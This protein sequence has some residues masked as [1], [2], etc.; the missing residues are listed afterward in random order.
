MA[1]VQGFTVLFAP[2]SL[3]GI[4]FGVWVL[5]MILVPVVRWVAGEGAERVGIA[6]GVIAQVGLVVSV[7]ISEFRFWALPVVIGVPLLGWLSEV[8]GS[9]TGI[10]FGR[11]S[12]TDVL[13]PQIAHV[14]L[15][16]PL[17]W[18]MMIPPS[19]AI[20]AV[21]AP[22]S[23]VL[24][25]LVAAAAFTAWDLY[26]DPQMVSWEFWKWERNGAYLGIPVSNYAGWFGVAF[27]I[28][29][30]F[31]MISRAAPLHLVVQVPQSPLVAVFV[32]TWILQF[33]G[34]MVFWKLRVSAVVGFL[35][36]GAFVA[37]AALR[38]AGVL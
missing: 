4:L 35:V 17:A 6:A 1:L 16:I 14:P 22:H 30:I 7:L 36:M 11:Y 37:L 31:S 8:I 27:L 13:K 34:Q 5:V 3:Q 20:G 26:L 9:R 19:W 28:A 12:Y 10:P 21:I 25:Y 38:A 32:I 33:V 2:L 24:Q 15:L 18:L 29:I 23:P